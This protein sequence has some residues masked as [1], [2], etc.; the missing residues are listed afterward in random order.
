MQTTEYSRKVAQAHRASKLRI[1]RKSLTHKVLFAW[2]EMAKSTR[3]LMNET[4]SETYL[5]SLLMLSNIAFF[6]S[7]TLKA[8]IV[9]HGGGVSLISM[10][11]G[12]LF[13]VAIVLRTGAMYLFSM[14]LAAV[15]RIFGG[16]GSWETTR[17]AVF[18]GALVAA[19]FGVAAAVLTVTFSN[20][21]VHY[22]IFGAGWI[23][24]PPYWFGALPF[25]WFISVGVAKV[26]GFSK[27]SPLFLSMSVVALVALMGAMYFHA[28]GMI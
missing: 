26:Q 21:A 22:P 9:P 10:E 13:V 14:I 17:L 23:S 25:V 16:T 28:R 15:C 19:P 8:V 5:L 7:W 20:L 11:I 27:T 3:R 2:F 1:S 12:G 6:L 24:M 18:W 4:P